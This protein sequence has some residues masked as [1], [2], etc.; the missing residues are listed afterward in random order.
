MPKKNGVEAPANGRDGARRSPLGIDLDRE[1]AADAVGIIQR[2]LDKVHESHQALQ[3]SGA[4]KLKHSSVK[5]AEVS[6]ATES[7][8]MDIMDGVGRA[9]EFVDRLET[10]QAPSEA[11]TG[12]R[13]ELFEIM[14]HLQFQDITTQQIQHTSSLLEEL[15]AELLDFVGRLENVGGLERD[16]RTGQSEGAS[17]FDPFATMG[18]AEDRQAAADEI[19]RVKHSSATANALQLMPVPARTG[20]LMRTAR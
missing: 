10:E 12:L 11:S 17:T 9:M 6:S 19:L 5:L 7:A 1:T 2:V 15:E 8:A 14:N 20:T 13:N 16:P 3:E 4:R 18:G